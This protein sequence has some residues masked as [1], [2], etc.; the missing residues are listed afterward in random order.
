MFK[1]LV[2]SFV[3]VLGSVTITLAEPAP[4]GK[5]KAQAGAQQAPAAKTFQ[6]QQ[7]STAQGK[8]QGDMQGQNRT[9]LGY[10]GVDE[11]TTASAGTTT[12]T[13]NTP[14]RRGPVARLMARIRA[15]F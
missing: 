12:T 10:R 6:N 7:P 13:R 11:E 14:T 9:T 15:R 5:A 1:I 8:Q 3:L 4:T 2:W